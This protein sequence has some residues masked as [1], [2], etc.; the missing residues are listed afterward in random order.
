MLLFLPL[1]FV[2]SVSETDFRGELLENRPICGL[3]RPMWGGRG[4]HDHHL[5]IFNSL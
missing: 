4:T 5:G 2:L 3:T 1:L